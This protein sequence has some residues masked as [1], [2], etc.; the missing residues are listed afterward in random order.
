MIKPAVVSVLSIATGALVWPYATAGTLYSLHPIAMGIFAA[1]S[2][3]A[4]VTLQRT[5]EE[6]KT[7]AARAK[8]LDLH[9]ALQLLAVTS[10]T[11]GF[12]A[13]YTVGAPVCPPLFSVPA[14]NKINNNRAH[15]KTPH[16][17]LGVTVYTLSLATTVAGILLKNG[18][19][20]RKYTYAH[21]YFGLAS[22]FGTVLTAAV[23]LVLYYDKKAMGPVAGPLIALAFT[24]S[25]LVALY[26]PLN[27]GS[28][29][30]AKKQ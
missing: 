20:S 12:Y 7:A 23:G 1:S 29:G 9:G 25:A 26:N 5:T 13:I 15:F 2:I 3:G 8:N 19:V 27:L 17:I 6:S 28:K 18:V 24:G 16:G 11:V 14:H 21:R 30:A 10:A 22:L 4:V